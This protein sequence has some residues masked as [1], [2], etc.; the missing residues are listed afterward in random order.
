MKARD[1]EQRRLIQAA[2]DQGWTVVSKAKNIQLRSPD[3]E[4]M[5]TIHTS[6][7]DYRANKNTRSRLR[8]MGVD[9]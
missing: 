4:S 6:E 3:G 1:K 2:V 9:V 5:V 8:R 7:S